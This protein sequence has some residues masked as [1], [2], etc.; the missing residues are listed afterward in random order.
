[1]DWN[2]FRLTTRLN[3]SGKLIE[4]IYMIVAEIDGVKNSWQLSRKLQ[5][6]TIERLT[7]AV[8]VT[9]TGSSNRIEGNRLTDE[10][11]ND[12][13]RNLRIKKFRTRDEQ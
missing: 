12:L 2:N 13:Y 11:V 3:F 5:P 1:M 10:Q 9:S 7:Y 4:E 8:I 6:Q